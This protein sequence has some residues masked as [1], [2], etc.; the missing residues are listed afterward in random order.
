MPVYNAEQTLSDAIESILR[1]TV[2]DF[3]YII[4]DDG[5]H[6]RSPEI[7]DRYAR[8]SSRIVPVRLDRSGI[9]EALNAGLKKAPG[10]YIAR[11]DAD[12]ISHPERLELQAALLDKNPRTDVVSCLVH[13]LR[14]GGYQ[15]GYARYIRWINSLTTPREI[16]INR[17]IE[18]PLAHPSVMFRRQT[19]E[20][21]GAYRQGDFPEDYELWLRWLE[22]GARIQKIPQT[23]LQ[24]RD[25][26]D[27]LSRTDPRYSTDSFYRIK[28]GYLARWL[29]VNNPHH[30]E[31]L[32]WGAGKTSRQRAE[33]LTGYGIRITGYVDVDPKKIGN[34]I[35]GRNITSYKELP[36]A[37][38]VF[39][40]SY[41]G[42]RGANQQIREIL[43]GRGYRAGREFLF[44]S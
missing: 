40:V 29:A 15:Q 26:P 6:D 44:A 27:R 43:T 24:W 22:Q 5:S 8:R 1:Q 18:S 11:M 30:P 31:I 13:H 16:R 41:V 34:T 37:G 7:I 36:P 33:Y 12:D 10:S 9:V 42:L 14:E 38:K 35:G 4:V 28:A 20:E 2:T 39:V 23:L 32:L 17:F 19:V 3:E 21:Y 25:R